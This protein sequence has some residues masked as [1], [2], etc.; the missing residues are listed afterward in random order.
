[1]SFT[2]VQ[3][4]PIFVDLLAQANDNGWSFDGTQARHETCNAGNLYFIGQGIVPGVTYTIN[5]Q[6]LSISGGYLQGFIGG[7]GSAHIT[8]PG[9]YKATFTA[10]GGA[11]G[12]SYFYSDA[13]C[14]LEFFSIQTVPVP[15]SE[16]QQNTIAYNDRAD[17]W[18]AFYTKVPDIGGFLFEK[19]FEYLQGNLYISEHGTD[20]RCN[21]F[22]DQFPAT[23]I[24]TTNQQSTLAKTFIAINYQADALLVSPSLINTSLGQAS[25]LNA[26]D[27][28]A[29]TYND[30][31]VI[32]T[33]DGLYQAYFLRDMTVD[34]INGD[35][36]KG[37]WMKV[38]LQTASPSSVLN[39]F[40]TEIQYN[41]SYQN[42]R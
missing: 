4:Q 14:V 18:G 20:N 19:T 11:A 31:S 27:F 24:F 23:I 38:G 29:E 21:F 6:V 16:Y 25:E 41:H 5:F 42:I 39:L 13:N 2:A 9:Q 32:Y 34:L 28:I 1:M 40:T 8:S 10:M 12:D 22:G 3:E 15:I 30:G 33:S 7:V 17:K 35:P 26:S 37:N 36:L